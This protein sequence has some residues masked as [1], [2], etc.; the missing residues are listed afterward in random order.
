MAFVKKIAIEVGI[1]VLSLSSIG[2]AADATSSWQ[3]EWEKTLEAARKEGQVTLYFKAGYDGVVPEF[4]KKYPK[5]KVVTVAGEAADMTNR[6][7]AERR[8]EKYIADVFTIG[9]R[10][11]Q[12]IM[13]AEAVDPIRPLLLLP[14]VVDETKWF[15]GHVYS[16]PE[17]KYIFRYLSVAEQGMGYN[18]NLLKDPKQ[19]QSYWDFLNPNWKGKIVA[20]DLRT[21]GPGNGNMSFWYHNPELGPDF[22]RRLY[23]E[24][25]IT[26]TRSSRQATDWLAHGKFTFCF[27]CSGFIEKAEGQGLPV[28][29]LD[30]DWK[31]GAGVVSQSGNLLFLKNA[32]HPNAGRVFINWLLSRE[33]QI[34]I[35]RVLAKVQ[36]A[37][38]RRI[39]I[40]KD[41]VPAEIR[42]REGGKYMDMDSRPEY[43]DR[44]PFLKL[45]GEVLNR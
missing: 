7:L 14:E 13:R 22:V 2:Y 38:S 20:R 26:L 3:V 36:P 9:I 37:E 18:K 27:F 24:M 44:K 28:G 43:R 1:I 29:T 8:G 25:D 6:L 23:S 34:E 10:S 11:A 12:S 5:I 31:E 45:L 21:P 15:Q 35:Q 41:D 42:R 19:M 17:K 33:G 16:D 40:P 30:V 4:Q 39:D 32:P